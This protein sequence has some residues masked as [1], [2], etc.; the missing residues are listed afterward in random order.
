MAVEM[1]LRRNARV[2]YSIWLGTCYTQR[3]AYIFCLDPFV[4][5]A[6]P[7]ELHIKIDSSKKRPIGEHMHV[8]L[9]V[10]RDTINV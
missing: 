8:P 2:F 3:A 10:F 1:I 6:C 4:N 7:L 9:C 5:L